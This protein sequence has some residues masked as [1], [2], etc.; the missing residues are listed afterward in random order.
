M[1]YLRRA[2]NSHRLVPAGLSVVHYD[3][4]NPGWASV[5]Q[6]R[7]PRYMAFRSRSSVWWRCG[8]VPAEHPVDY[9]RRTAHGGFPRSD[10]ISV[11]HHDHRDSVRFAAFQI[12]KTGADAV[13]SGDCPD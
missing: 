5:L 4:R 10:W 11:L 2:C 13:R 7:K 6:V 3:H 12:C 9:L 8:A 1:D